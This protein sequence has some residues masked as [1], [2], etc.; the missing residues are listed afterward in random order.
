MGKKHRDLASTTPNPLA[1]KERPPWSQRCTGMP[2]KTTLHLLIGGLGKVS[3]AGDHL[4]KRIR[5]PPTDRQPSST[6][7]STVCST[8]HIARKEEEVTLT[9]SHPLLEAFTSL[10]RTSSTSA[11]PSSMVTLRHLCSQVFLTCNSFIV[12][13]QASNHHLL[14]TP[15]A[16]G[17]GRRA[18]R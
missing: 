8:S 7:L 12:S 1:K 6:S 9:T 16:S 5:A 2:S 4:C 3:L 13:L 18:S 11:C 10:L 14:A 17:R 15:N